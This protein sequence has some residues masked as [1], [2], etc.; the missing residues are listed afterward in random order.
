VALNF[1]VELRSS[2]TYTWHLQDICRSKNLGSRKVRVI[3]L[4]KTCLYRRQ[5]QV[6]RFGESSV[7]AVLLL[8]M[9]TLLSTNI[10]VQELP[11]WWQK[12]FSHTVGQ[13]LLNTF[14]CK[15]T[16]HW[17]LDITDIHYR[18]VDQTVSRKHMFF[19]QI[20]GFSAC[21]VLPEPL[22]VHNHNKL[23]SG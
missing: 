10:Y 15:Y 3:T 2:V 7:N 20:K 1:I 23:L 5:A 6:T 22:P 16:D 17:M 14:K 4:L 12:G 18:E 19:N 13:I 9:L 21:S 11:W 8:T